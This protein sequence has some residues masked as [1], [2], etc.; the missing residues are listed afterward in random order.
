MKD[1]LKALDGAIEGIEIPK[2]LQGRVEVCQWTKAPQYSIVAR[3]D[4][5]LGGKASPPVQTHSIDGINKVL[6]MLAFV[7]EQMDRTREVVVQVLKGEHQM[8]QLLSENAPWPKDPV[9]RK[10]AKEARLKEMIEAGEITFGYPQGRM[11]TA[12][13]EEI[14]EAGERFLA[15]NKKR[16]ERLFGNDQ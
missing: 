4:G 1:E 16:Y 13:A 11:T 15:D 10:A 14:K 12:T 9:E 2:S 8:Y 5:F 6:A 7:M 3:P